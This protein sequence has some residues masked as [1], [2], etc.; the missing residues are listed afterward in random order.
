MTEWLAVGLTVVL[1]AASAILTFIAWTA[2]RR[3]EER[4]FL[5]ITLAFFVVFVTGI[6]ALLDE[7][8]DLFHEQFAIEPGPLV[9]IVFSQGLLYLA[10]LRGSRP[11][12]TDGNG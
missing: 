10:L 1:V 3:F 7:T 2:T 9:L 11:R 12:G 6:V 4:R 5:L 8:I